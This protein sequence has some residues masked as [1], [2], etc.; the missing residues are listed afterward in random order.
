MSAGNLKR[1][2]DEANGATEEQKSFRAV[3]S[4]ERSRLE[5]LERLLAEH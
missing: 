3:F 5:N 2:A 4:S 1:S